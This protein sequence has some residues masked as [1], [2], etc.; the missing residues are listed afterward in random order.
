M[1]KTLIY[2]YCHDYIHKGAQGLDSCI[3]TW[4]VLCFMLRHGNW[5]EYDISNYP[6][7]TI[8]RP[9]FLQK[10]SPN[11]NT[12]VARQ[13]K[14]I[15]ELKNKASHQSKAEVT[16]VNCQVWAIADENVCIVKNFGIYKDCPNVGKTGKVWKMT[17]IESGCMRCTIKWSKRCDC[18]IW[19]QK[20]L[21]KSLWKFGLWAHKKA[22]K[23]SCQW[24][25][26]I[27]V[28]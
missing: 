18:H 25:R 2:R 21:H 23:L 11:F 15:G 5:L 10:K 13:Q 12:G 24:W 16:I 8:N 27:V 17:A 4:T 3:R 28:A 20:L 7:Y 19:W 14:V 26:R 9:F 6:Q 22:K 1:S